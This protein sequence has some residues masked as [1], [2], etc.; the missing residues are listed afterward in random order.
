MTATLRLERTA[1]IPQG[2]RCIAYV[3]VSTEKQA[4]ETKVPPDTQLARCKAL[5]AE[6][7]LTVEHV[8][9]DH[10]SGAHVERLDRLAAA[11]QAHP[12][13]Q[14][15]RGLIVVYDPSRWGRFE[16]PGMDRMFREQLYRLG[17]DVR[18]GDEPETDHEAANLFVSTGQAIAASE[19]RRQLRQK[20]I[21]NMPKIAR[22]GFWQGRAPFGY[23]IVEVLEGK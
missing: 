5:A 15:H 21:D 11:C 20:V 13:P 3:R 12:P 22:Q 14:G 4:G 2:T 10:E 8:I 9:E 19:Y 18:I 23:S 7:G 17:W 16:R 6:R 1:L